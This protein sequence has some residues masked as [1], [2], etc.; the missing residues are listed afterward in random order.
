MLLFNPIFDPSPGVS[1]EVILE[2][3]KSVKGPDFPFPMTA[4]TGVSIALSDY[5]TELSESDS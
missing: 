1:F 4:I 5:E 2:A 3:M